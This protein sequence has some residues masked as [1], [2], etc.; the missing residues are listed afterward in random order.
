MNTLIRFLRKGSM[1]LEVA[2]GWEL[3]IDEGPEWL[4]LRLTRAE[5]DSVP[6]PPLSATVWNESRLRNRKRLVFELDHGTLLTSFLV[7]Q[8][9][10][11]HKRAEIEGG[12]FRVCDL[13]E[14][15]C[16]TLSRMRMADRFPNYR[17][18]E[19]AVLGRRPQM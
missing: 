2:K 13:S 14:H 16:S 3:T 11:L 17:T 9:V 18:R 8:L 12:V 19:D 15:A 6:E 5:V 4:F 7:G 1:M 10:L